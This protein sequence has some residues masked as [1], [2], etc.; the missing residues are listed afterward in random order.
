MRRL[1]ILCALALTVTL[2]AGVAPPAS[3]Y[4][5][6]PGPVFNKPKPWGG[7]A[8]NNRI[9]KAV[10]KAIR[11]AQKGPN[12]DN[13][14]ILISTFLMDRKAS[15]DALIGA[16]RRGVSVRVIIDEEI[17][18]KNSRRLVSK[19]N[20]DNL[21]DRNGDGRVDA[22]RTGKCGRAT[23]GSGRVVRGPDAG[24][25]PLMSRVQANRSLARPS[26]Q[27]ESWGRDG[28]YVKKC[29]GSCRRTGTAGNMHSKF[30]VF[31][32]TG[33]TNN[34]VM[35]SSSNLN[36][37]GAK[38]GWNDLMIM[39]GKRKAVKFY[40]TIHGAMTDAKP[41]RPVKKVQIGDGGF[42]SRFYP[43][44]RATR[45]TDP[46]MED[47]RQIR[48]GPRGDRTRIHVSMF[49]WKGQRGNWIAD[50]LLNLA[51]QGCII[52]VIYG[53][54]STQIASRLRTAA[55]NLGNFHLWDSRW[56]CHGNDGWSEV[57]T[58]AKYVLVKGRY[59]SRKNAFQV[60]TGTPNWVMGS[61]R[62][63]DENSVNV[64]SR[65]IYS[66]Y[67]NNWNQVRTYSRR[68]PY[69]KYG[70]PGPGHPALKNCPNARENLGY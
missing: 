67:L 55:G 62:L 6:P 4:R 34:V 37:G 17:N 22:P 19:L 25:A 66:R 49:Y 59:R 30:Y 50:K 35:V 27:K 43:M 33:Q 61:L 21:V 40:T 39:R 68:M 2:L 38:L 20:G 23:S 10:E 46:V 56:D 18:N 48:C 64:N 47:L 65:R 41:Q 3:A 45:S 51:R 32:R 69:S 16:C 57:R 60:W 12:H 58:H 13:P 63:S 7:T 11:N 52:K 8:A 9:V 70:K 1:S 24:D 42:T 53:A 44:R 36:R 54:P 31:S 28:S 26:G 14:Y 15:V 5:P 29:S